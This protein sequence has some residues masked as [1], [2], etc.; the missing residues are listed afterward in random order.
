MRGLITLCLL[1]ACGGEDAEEPTI[2]PANPEAERPQLADAPASAWPT[3]LVDLRASVEE[4]ETRASCE[5]RLRAQMPVELAESLAD[6]GYDAV[7][8]DICI[9]LHAAKEA[10]PALCEESSVRTTREG[11]LRRLAIH[12]GQPDLCPSSRGVP[13]RDPL[14]VA[15]AGR[16]ARQC[17][18]LTGGLRRTCQAVLRNDA[19]GCRDDEGC[20]ARVA[21]YGSVVESEVPDSFPATEVK[22]VVRRER[23]ALEATFPLDAGVHLAAIEGCAWQLTLDVGELFRDQPRF[24]LDARLAPDEVSVTRARL[25]LPGAVQ[26]GDLVDPTLTVSEARA[27]GDALT[28]ALRGTFRRDGTDTPVELDVRTWIRDADPLR[29]CAD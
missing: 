20:T 13:G 28:I 18:A 21:R 29:G 11:C 9:G 3:D 17:L 12:A 27:R 14:C 1:L 23:G 8:R 15:W 22:L 16:A 4:F 10:N 24:R 25:M 2:A 26:Q 5:S 6:L 7:L 19:E